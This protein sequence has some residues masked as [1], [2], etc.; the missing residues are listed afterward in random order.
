MKTWFVYIIHC[1]DD[2]LYTGITTDIE[3]RY[4]QHALQQGAK[5]FRARKPKKL[6]Y[7]ESG[8]NRSTA[9][10]QEMEIKKLSRASKF[11]LIASQ[12]NQ[13]EKLLQ[14]VVIKDCDL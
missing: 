2:T 10:K 7:L 6:V 12:Q 3:R 1:T 8:H 13:I 11:Q 5:Y 9:S 4:T 14:G